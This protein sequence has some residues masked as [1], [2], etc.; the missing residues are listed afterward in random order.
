MGPPY[1]YHRQAGDDL[2]GKNMKDKCVGMEA[3][4]MVSKIEKLKE[5]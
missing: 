3:K 1:Q 5:I 2:V 4:V